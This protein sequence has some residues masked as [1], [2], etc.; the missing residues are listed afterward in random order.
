MKQHA[1]A[2]GA[3]SPLRPSGPPSAL[4]SAPWDAG[5]R[6]RIAVTLQL[7]AGF[8]PCQAQQ[9]DKFWKEVR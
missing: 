2:D 4:F 8:G 6:V 5:P 3:A 9:G 1:K 7:L